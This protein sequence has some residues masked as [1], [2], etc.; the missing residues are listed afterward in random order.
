MRRALARPQVGH[1]EIG[2]AAFHRLAG[3]A[4]G[5]EAAGKQRLAARV[6]GRHRAPGDQRVSKTC[7]TL[8]SLQLRV[9][10]V[11]QRVAHD[12]LLRTVERGELVPSRVFNLAL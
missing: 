12:L 4:Q 9:Q 6:V 11:A 1:A 2:R 8:G 5:L 10:E 3:E 7:I